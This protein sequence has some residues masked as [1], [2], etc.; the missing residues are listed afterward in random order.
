M[1][2]AG[3]QAVL[4]RANLWLR[5]AIRVLT[6]V[7]EAQHDRMASDGNDSTCGRNMANH[8]D[9]PSSRTSVESTNPAPADY[10]DPVVEAYK[11]D[12]DRTLLRE[13]LKLTVQQR[14]EKLE[15]FVQFARELREAGTR[16]RGQIRQS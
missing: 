7:L 12:V 5:T 10:I 6:P 16:S 2:F 11:K 9:E 14:F 1:A 13:N 3:D 4:Y 15:S 8:R